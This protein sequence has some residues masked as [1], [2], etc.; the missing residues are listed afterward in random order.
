MKTTSKELKLRARKRLKGKYGICVGA[1]LIAGALMSVVFMIFLMVSVVLG[2]AN[3][4]LFYGG[5]EFGVG[6]V[7]MQ[8]AIII[9]TVVISAVMALFLPGMM[10]MYYNISTDQKYGLYDL[11]FA[12]KN[13]PLKFLGLYF[14]I[15]LI[16]IVLSI[17]YFI[18]LIVSIITDFIPIMIVLL[19]L[20]YLLLL[21]GSLMC[22]IYFSQ[23]F[24]ILMES[25]DKGVL[26]SMRES[27]ELMR[28]NKGRFFYI[29]LS[30]T[31]MILLGYGSF[32][33]GFLWIFPYVHCT[34]TEFYL[35]IKAEKTN[36][37]LAS[38]MDSSYESMQI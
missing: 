5:S 25:T 10:K 7:L 26:Q 14:M 29:I 6:F 16:S 38:P 17:P 35:D 22:S 2:V 9:F 3:E 15:V 18:V 11:L 23:S 19:V 12:L 34:F 21:V 4:T 30:F 33:I 20:M 32:G 27:V 36:I 28:G 31:G 37:I 8:A 13:K 24:F 1:G